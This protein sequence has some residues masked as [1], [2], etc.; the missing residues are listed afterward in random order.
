MTTRRSREKAQAGL[1][2]HPHQLGGFH[3]E[4][5]KIVA[6]GLGNHFLRP[7]QVITRIHQIAGGLHGFGAANAAQNGGHGVGVGQDVF[8]GVE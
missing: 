5:S 7:V 6:K 8:T 2:L 1:A 3:G 4:I